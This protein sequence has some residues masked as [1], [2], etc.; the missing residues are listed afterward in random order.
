MARRALCNRRDTAFRIKKEKANDNYLNEKSITKAAD[1]DTKLEGSQGET[2][3]QVTSGNE[4]TGSKHKSKRRKR[5][6][7][8]SGDQRSDDDDPAT[9]SNHL[10]QK[11]TK[12]P[13]QPE[14]EHQENRE[15][16][17]GMIS[18]DEAYLMM[19]SAWHGM[20]GLKSIA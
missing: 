11:K 3:A 10:S 1:D 8:P 2:G 15:P 6:P 9:G 20:K 19:K 13:K 7:S 4:N 16:L 14:P 17:V 5:R 12:K 18:A